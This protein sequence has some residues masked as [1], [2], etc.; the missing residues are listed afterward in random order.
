MIG[1]FRIGAAIV[2]IAAA[3]GASTSAVATEPTYECT[4]DREGHM[5]HAV[6]PHTPNMFYAYVCQGG[7][8]RFL[9][10]CDPGSC[11]MPEPGGPGVDI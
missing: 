3:M 4:L 11:P 10:I 8:W 5:F 1:S 9:G 7:A 2:L 6:D